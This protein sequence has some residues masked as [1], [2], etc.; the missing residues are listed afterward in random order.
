MWFGT[1]GL[2]VHYRLS[3][4]QVDL[5]G[6]CD[7]WPIPWEELLGRRDRAGLTNGEDVLSVLFPDA[8]KTPAQ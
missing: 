8:V 1:F 6:P 5:N 2:L 3:G 7:A 4:L